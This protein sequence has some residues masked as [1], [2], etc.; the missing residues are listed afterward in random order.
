MNIERMEKLID[1]LKELPFEKFN[2]ASWFVDRYG[3][4]QNEVSA[5]PTKIGCGTSACV[6]GHAVHLFMKEQMPSQ[7]LIRGAA[8]ELLDLS[9]LE[10]EYLLIGKFRYMGQARNTWSELS[11]VT[12]TET[13]AAMEFMI[14]NSIE[15]NERYLTDY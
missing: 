2:M 11:S 3:W 10:S 4:A 15:G 8:E 13:I 1:Y 5:L 12:I 14:A 9:Y 6:A 7:L